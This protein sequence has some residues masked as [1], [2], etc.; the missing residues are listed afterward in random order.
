MLWV[1]PLMGKIVNQDQYLIPRSIREI[2]T[3]I[4]VLGGGGGF[5]PHFPLTLFVLCRS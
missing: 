2:S 1:S 5:L 3:T 4:K